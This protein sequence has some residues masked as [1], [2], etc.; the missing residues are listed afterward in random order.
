V[1]YCTFVV[2]QVEMNCIH[3]ITHCVLCREGFG[4][5]WTGIGSLARMDSGVIPNFHPSHKG[6]W[7]EVTAEGFNFL[8]APFHVGFQP[9]RGPIFLVTLDAGVVL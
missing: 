6:H 1:A 8:M 9:F 3:V 7:A 5:Y 2:L 4:T